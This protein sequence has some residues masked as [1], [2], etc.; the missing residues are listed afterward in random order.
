MPLVTNRRAVSARVR[1]CVDRELRFM[2]K[3]THSRAAVPGREDGSPID[4]RLSPGDDQPH[5]LSSEWV[6]APTGRS[7]FFN[8]AVDVPAFNRRLWV[9]RSIDCDRRDQIRL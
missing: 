6:V 1:S 5:I 9:E 4:S 8:Q 3:Q 2:A 7:T